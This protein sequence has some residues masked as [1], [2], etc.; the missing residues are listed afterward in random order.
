MRSFSLIYIHLKSCPDLS[1]RSP[2]PPAALVGSMARKEIDLAQTAAMPSNYGCPI[3]CRQASDEASLKSI[4]GILDA[5]DVVDG[6][7]PSRVIR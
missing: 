5:F 1:G 4:A 2:K 3:K 7:F 6:I